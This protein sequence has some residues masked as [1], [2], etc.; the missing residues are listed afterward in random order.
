M[1]DIQ[2]PVCGRYNP[3]GTAFCQNCGTS[4]ANQDTA[5]IQPGDKPTRKATAELEPILPDWLREARD[6]ARKTAEDDTQRKS[7]IPS[8]PSAS[9]A[10][11][12]A[13]LQSQAADE[14]EEIPDWLAGIT[15]AAKKTKTPTDE[16]KETSAESR[17]V[18]VG[19]P[20]DFESSG[21]SAGIQAAQPPTESS[22]ESGLP[23]WL[24]N[25][26]SAQPEN[27]GPDE[28]T[29]WLKKADSDRGGMTP[30]STEPA[31]STPEPSIDSGKVVSD[32]DAVPDWLT[33][34]QAEGTMAEAETPKS[35]AESA[36]AWMN[37]DETSAAPEASALEEVPDWLKNLESTTEPAAPAE[38]PARETPDWLKS[39]AAE[40][41]APPSSAPASEP[42]MELP[43]WMRSE[44][45][46]PSEI[47]SAEAD[48]P[49]WLDQ[50]G[51]PPADKPALTE[52][53]AAE[54]IVPAEMPDWLAAFRPA[55]EPVSEPAPMF[56]P[57]QEESALG[58]EPLSGNELDRLFAPDKVDWLSNAEAGQADK[59]K[60]L[61]PAAEGADAIAPAALPSWVQAMRPVEASLGTTPHGVVGD[62]TLETTGP[63]A[64][65][66]GVLPSLPFAALT[67]KP[68]PISI[69]LQPSE[70]QQAHAALLD[71]TLAAESKPEP[72][73]T[74]RPMASQRVLYWALAILLVL[75][76]GGMFF[77]GSQAFPLPLGRPND[78]MAALA[79]V[80][81]VPQ[82]APVLVVFD[83]E[84]ALTGEMEAV[85]APLLDHLILL[86]HPRLA[87]ISTSPTG[88]A[89]AE[90]LF[91]GLLHDLNYQS[92]SQ[93]VNLG[94]LPGGLSG[95][96]AFAQNP[97][98][99]APF[100]S[101]STLLNPTTAW[102]TAPLQGVTSFSNFAAIIV[103]TD[104]IESGRTWIEQ[105]GPLRGDAQFVMVSS[106]QAGPM[107]QPYFQSGQINGLM[108][109]LYDSSVIEQYN[110]DRPGLARRYWD[111]YNIGLWLAVILILFGSLWSLAAGWR[112]RS[113]MKEMGG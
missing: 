73:T 46:K 64:G 75:A 29:D 82:D 11:L 53:G 95:V 70:E 32:S 4:L 56:E 20:G 90:R 3:E 35:P 55:G 10:D 111:A 94:Y 69:K 112:E 91:S 45:S 16:L 6:K 1:A 54:E 57:D 105:A 43:A 89:L 49:A 33:K 60:Q 86:R 30:T 26:T 13:G 14:E 65:L 58:S 50:A 78:V 59:T 103:I 80:E 28:L 18:D 83:Y 44:D 12:L 79:S 63:L 23:S 61:P 17:F 107:F 71:Q 21:D 101:D 113:A 15:G 27:A 5:S 97:S 36:A 109:G 22:E 93:Y 76:V 87:A 88:A 110:A 38:Q 52:P 24:Q 41:P 34:L 74:A 19:R 47:K 9:S 106:A 68:K 39:F 25:I 81:A 62:E 42:E 85:A 67:N 100:T 8:Q 99:V 84:P 96:R 7:D 40:E 66:H 108:T 31:S 2:C 48:L 37:R 77:S 104:S 92:G 51:E 98:A 102:Q 72:M